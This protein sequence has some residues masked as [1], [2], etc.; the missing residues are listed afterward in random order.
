MTEEDSCKRKR[1]YDYKKLSIKYLRAK[2]IKVSKISVKKIKAEK[3]IVKDAI[4]ENAN[5]T[6]V[7]AEKVTIGG[8]EINP[9]YAQSQFSQRN[10]VSEPAPNQF[11][12]KTS[13]TKCEILNIDYPGSNLLI[14]PAVIQEVGTD[15]TTAI[16]QMA[17]DIILPP[18]NYSNPDNTTLFYVVI[19]YTSDINLTTNHFYNF[20]TN[21]FDIVPSGTPLSDSEN[22]LLTY[23]TKRLISNQWQDLHLAGLLSQEESESIQQVQSTLP[24]PVL[25][26]P[27][28]FFTNTI[29]ISFVVVTTA[30][31][32]NSTPMFCPGSK[33]QLIY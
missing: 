18:Q 16:R 12:V 7:V 21:Q 17:F 33:V 23:G 19:G 25:I 3:A 31:S 2:A 8:I 6:N 28:T 14:Y 32:G 9:F 15:S 4:V 30:N 22:Y 20:T 29:Y 11:V 10:E 27:F 24:P 5:V 1:K 13:S 26:P